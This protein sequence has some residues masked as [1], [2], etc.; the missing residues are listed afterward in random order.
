[1]NNI[2]QTH[3][4]F[5]KLSPRE[6]QV[7]QAAKEGKSIQETAD[8]LAIKPCTVKAYRA[9]I[10]LKLGCDNTTS[11]VVSLIEAGIL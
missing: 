2:Q 6:M 9:R 7:A 8:L 5:K 11:S 3:D 1:V 10:M 4:I